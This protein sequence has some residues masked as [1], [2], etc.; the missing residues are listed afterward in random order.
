MDNQTSSAPASEQF[1]LERTFDAPREL[2][3]RAWTDPDHFKR[4][5]APQNFDTPVAKIDLRPGGMNL[6]CMRDPDGKEFWGKKVYRE[7]VEPERLVYLDSFCD[8]EGNTVDASTYGM[9][10][11]PAEVLTT[12]TFDDD[13]G[14]TRITITSEVPMALAAK[15]GALEG[16]G[17]TLDKLAAFLATE[18]A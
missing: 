2:V 16:W 1:H 15:H 11:W 5:F 10:D 18:Q 13:G 3:W 7:I 4:W 6:F 14:K 17:Q 9:S 12:V 8:A